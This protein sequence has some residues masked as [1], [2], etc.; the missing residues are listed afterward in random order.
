MMRL[1]VENRSLL[2]LVGGF[3]FCPCHLPLTL[4][5]LG[6]ALAG[7]AVGVVLRDH[8]V[9]AALIISSVWVLATWRGLWLLRTKPSCEIPSTRDVQ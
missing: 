4:G 6:V 8:V 3:L 1:S 2:W 7:T 5:L 9:L